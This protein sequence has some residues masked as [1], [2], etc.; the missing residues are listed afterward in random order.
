[1]S[2]PGAGKY[3]QAFSWLYY[4]CMLTDGNPNTYLF[5]TKQFI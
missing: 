1:M 3:Q 4:Q 5:I 2:A